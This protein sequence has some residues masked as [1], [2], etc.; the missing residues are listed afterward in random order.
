MPGS[1][2]VYAYRNGVAGVGKVCVISHL[3]IISFVLYRTRC[4]RREFV[5]IHERY[6][7][8]SLDKE[9]TTGCV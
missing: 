1:I 2:R 9:E 4:C 7:K 8:I 6:G 5:F 3:L